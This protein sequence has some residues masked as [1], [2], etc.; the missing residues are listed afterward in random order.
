MITL[1]FTI[2][3]AARV[4]RAIPLELEEAAQVDG[5]TRFRRVPQDRLPAARA[6]ACWPPR[7]SAS[8]PR[9]TSS[10]S[11]TSLII[12]DQDNRTLPVWLSSFHN[13]FGTD[14][15]ATMAASTLFMLPALRG[16]PA[17]P[18][19]RHLR[20]RRRRRQGLRPATTRAPPPSSATPPGDRSVPAHRPAPRPPPPAHQAVLRPGHFTLDADTALRVGA[21]AEPAAATAAHPARP[22]HRAAA[23]TVAGRAVVLALD[24]QLGGLGEEGYVLT[25]DPHAVLLRAAHPTGLLRGIQTIRQLLPSAGPVG[26]PAA[27]VAV[28]AAVRRDP[29]RPASSPG[30]GRC[31]TWHGTSSR[32]SLPAPVRRPAGPAQAQRPASAPHRRPGLAHAGRRLPPAHRDRRPPRRVAEGPRPAAALRRHPPRRGVHRG[33]TARARAV[34]RRSRR[35]RHA[36]DRDARPCAG[37]PRRLSRSWATTRSARLDV[38]TR[39]GVCDTVLGVHDEVL[40]FCRTVLDEVMDVFPSPYIHVGGE[41][42]PTTE[43]DEQRRRARTRGW[44]EGLRGPRGAARLVPRPDRRLPRPARALPG[45]L[46]RDRHRTAPGLHRDDLARPVPRPGRGPPRPPRRQRAPP[47]HVPGLRPVRRAARAAGPARS[48]RRSAGRPRPRPRT[49]RTRT[50]RPAGR[51]LGTQAQLW[52]EFVTHA[53]PYRVPHLPAAVRPRRPR[54]ERRDRLADFRCPPRRAHRPARRARASTH[55]P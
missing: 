16:L 37:R 26:D 22:R 31:W 24:S 55:H 7:C 39:W 42:C 51:V 54:L 35:H 15:G 20:L 47:G 9:G 13:T 34:R 30:A 45:R 6:R 21:G 27:R 18:A 12:K 19:P 29:R 46:G 32:S 4:P 25:V 33:R 14:W 11:P 43:W 28:A 44:R 36:G 52:T 48:R 50:R 1:P 23:G 5:C 3:D 10:P 38:W 49:R 41:E 17:A 53:R 2:A 40:D 8:S